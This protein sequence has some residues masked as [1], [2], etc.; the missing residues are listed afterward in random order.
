MCLVAQ[1]GKLDVVK[2]FIDNDVHVVDSDSVKDTPLHAACR[3][4]H[5]DVIRFLV[6]EKKYSLERKIS[7]GETPVHVAAVEGHDEVVQFLLGQKCQPLPLDKEGNTPLHVAAHHGHVKVVKALINCGACVDCTMKNKRGR[8]P[9]HE[10]CC[11][12]TG[13]LEALS[14]LVDSGLFNCNDQDQEGNTPLH[15]A[16]MYGRGDCIEGLYKKTNRSIK[17]NRGQMPIDAANSKGTVHVC[18][19]CIEYY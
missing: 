2:F 9:L 17:N 8:T 16:C 19:K 7:T 5:L 10:V 4:G 15:M 1:Y 6:V 18:L 14:I 3:G 13:S 12:T 11:S